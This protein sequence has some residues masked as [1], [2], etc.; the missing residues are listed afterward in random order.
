LEQI[1]LALGKLLRPLQ[2]FAGDGDPV[3]A[4]NRFG[5][6]LPGAAG[7]DPAL[8]ASLTYVVAAAG[9]LDPSITK[10]ATAI[11]AGDASQIVPA[12]VEL[13]EIVADVVHAIT[14]VADALSTVGAS[15]GLGGA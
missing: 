12:G 3:R 6:R 13:V 4:L 14:G 11:D 9:R 8:T 7:S 10:L 5:I 15:S 2:E 1:G